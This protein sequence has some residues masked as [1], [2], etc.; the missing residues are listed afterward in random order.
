MLKINGS[1]QDVK[2]V[3]SLSWWK[4]ESRFFVLIKSWNLRLLACGLLLFRFFNF[5]F[6][7]I[8]LF[9]CGH[10]DVIAPYRSLLKKF[11]LG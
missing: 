8:L 7:N 10:K 5:E 6:Q 3:F 2:A 11:F 9:M 1:L 4:L